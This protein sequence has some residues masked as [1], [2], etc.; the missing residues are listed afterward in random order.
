M[1]KADFLETFQQ[2]LVASFEMHASS[3]VLDANGI[4]EAATRLHN[5]GG[6][7]SP[8][9]M[10]VIVGVLITQWAVYVAQDEHFMHPE[11]A[12]DY[13]IAKLDRILT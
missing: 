2:M 1:Q 5:L 3:E 11:E 8:Q 9:A 4:V 13:M 10:E 6:K 12:I 7:L